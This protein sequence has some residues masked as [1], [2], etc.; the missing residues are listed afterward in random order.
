MT[1]GL[2]PYRGPPMPMPALPPADAIPG[3]MPGAP[4]VPVTA[5]SAAAVQPLPANV[6]SAVAAGAAADQPAGTDI[7]PTS[8][9]V[10][11]PAS[12]AP[13]AKPDEEPASVVPKPRPAP[14]G[15]TSPIVTPKGAPA[16][17]WFRV[18]SAEAIIMMHQDSVT[19]NELKPLEISGTPAKFCI[20]PYRPVSS[21]PMVADGVAAALDALC[22]LLSKPL[23]PELA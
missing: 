20:A 17:K 21:S 2:T 19:S 9:A 3:M 5:V 4:P 22:R 15:W 16:V 18:P 10:P 13:P 14:S 7:P 1:R 23:V 11:I 12:V 8:A 6:A